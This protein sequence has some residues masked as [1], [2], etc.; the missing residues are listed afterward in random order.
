[1]STYTIDFENTTINGNKLRGKATLTI[2]DIV[3]EPP[4]QSG[5]ILYMDGINIHT[6]PR[7]SVTTTDKRLKFLSEN[8]IQIVRHRV[9][10]ENFVTDPTGTMKAIKDVADAADKYGLKVL[11]NPG[12][13]FELSS[14]FGTGGKGFP[15][16]MIQSLIGNRSNFATADDAKKAF[17]RRLYDNNGT[18]KGKKL[19]DAAADY[20]IQSHVNIVKDRP[21]S[22]GY[23]LY[24]EPPIFADSD[25][26]KL[27]A[28]VEYV[29]NKVV[30][31]DRDAHIFINHRHTRGGLPNQFF[32]AN[33]AKRTLPDI[34]N[35]R[36]VYTTHHYFKPADSFTYH[37]NK[38]AEFRQVLGVPILV[39]E[40][41]IRDIFPMDAARMK[42]WIDGL[43]QMGIPQIL[44]TF[45]G[46]QTQHTAYSDSYTENSR[47]VW[48]S[49]MA[50]MGRTTVGA[51]K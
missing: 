45:D 3:I 42:Q 5:D 14:Y 7:S 23:M 13:Q 38:L 24:N 51:P 28:Y 15:V 47:K 25:H 17:L 16:D 36:A 31:L 40:W 44:W 9:Y 10:W 18:Y 41:G 26:E 29:G 6:E 11:W 46:S 21:S 19:W 27:K 37:F 35:G 43:K 8:G 48:T 34:S 22:L 12:H 2:G 50:A 20:V 30:E 49:L 33:D 4:Q 39:S 32:N 1:M